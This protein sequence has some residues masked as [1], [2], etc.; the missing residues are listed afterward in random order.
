MDK[1][2]LILSEKPSAALKIAEALADKSP[3]KAVYLKKIP[4]YEL[5]H[6]GEKIIVVCA[7]GHLYTVTE[8]NKKG[9]TYPVFSM[10]WK[11][12][13]EVNKGSSFTK[14]YLDLI[15]KM[16]KESDQIII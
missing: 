10:E 13:Y 16:C 1:Y 5:T 2:I 3:K 11:P 15:K 4:Y 6:K 12:S 7:V 14:P 8:K 9:W